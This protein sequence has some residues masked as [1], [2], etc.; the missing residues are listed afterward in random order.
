MSN[1]KKKTIDV[2]DVGMPYS[3]FDVKSKTEVWFCDLLWNNTVIGMVK[4]K[5][6]K[7]V[8]KLSKRWSVSK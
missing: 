1:P 2:Y 6:L 8:E 5:N 7:E 4:G 3:D